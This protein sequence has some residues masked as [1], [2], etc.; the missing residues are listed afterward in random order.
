MTDLINK[1]SDKNN[2]NLNIS[3]NSSNVNSM[4]KKEKEGNNYPSLNIDSLHKFSF[5]GECM[6]QALQE[7]QESSKKNK[8]PNSYKKPLK[9]SN[10]KNLIQKIHIN[11][12]NNVNNEIC[13]PDNFNSFR[14]AD[15]NDTNINNSN[16][17]RISN[18][19]ISSSLV[20][21]ENRMTNLENLRKI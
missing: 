12:Q 20:N 6:Q 2:Q 1:K 10:N 4:N 3:D 5:G 9:N 21:L 17:E 14:S 16:N 15:N 7:M 13:L 19:K 11:Y 8:I 18:D